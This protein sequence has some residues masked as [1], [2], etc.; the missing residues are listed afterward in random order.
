LQDKGAETWIDW[1]WNGIFGERHVKAD[2]NYGYS[3]N[4]GER[5]TIDKTV[6]GPLLVSY[7]PESKSD[8]EECLLF[9]AKFQEKEAPPK[10]SKP[11]HSVCPER[12]GTLLMRRYLGQKK[13]AEAVEIER[14]WVTG[15][16]AGVAFRDRIYLFY[17][18][19]K[20]CAMRVLSFDAHTKTWDVGPRAYLPGTKGMEV[21]AGVIEDSQKVQ[22]LILFFRDPV[23]GAVRWTEHS[24]SG[25]GPLV[26]PIFISTMT[27]GLCFDSY[28]KEL[29]VGCG[30]DFDANK[31]SRWQLRRFRYDAGMLLG[32]DMEWVEGPNGF[33]AGHGRVNL[34]FQNTP[35]S[36]QKGRLYFIASGL[37]D[38]T[39]EA[40]G[41]WVAM[42][43]ADKSVR[44][45]W[46]TR[47]YYDEWTNSRSAP[48]ACW[49]QND[50]MLAS[51][52]IGGGDDDNNLYIA[53]YGLGIDTEPMG[54]FDDVSH[55]ANLGLERST[56][57]FAK[58]K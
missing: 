26:G 54:D 8:Q 53:Y 6:C 13:W 33:D 25:I 28:A 18:M 23:S 42:Q 32:N 38:P 27:P 55:I 2:I 35:D 57:Y 11:P 45:G 58:E 20:N 51:R 15:D 3:T 1:N 40:S 49:F 46:L 5:Q 43:I 17:P 29:V 24:E 37:R 10:D 36:G 22:R 50:I 14:K 16:P 48:A 21:S 30:Q 44:D 31:K 52:W 34:L 9:L 47:R 19:E 12:P 41:Y 4:G 39:S 56:L 7:K